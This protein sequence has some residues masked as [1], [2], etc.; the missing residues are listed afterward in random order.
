MEELEVLAQRSTERGER[1]GGKKGGQ[2]RVVH[3]ACVEM[4]E[5]REV[6]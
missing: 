1:K 5:T 2:E 3:P 4:N 6:Q